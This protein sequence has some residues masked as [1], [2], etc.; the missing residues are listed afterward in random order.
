MLRFF[1]LATIL[2]Y[3]RHGLLL[4]AFYIKM[5]AVSQIKKRWW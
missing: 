2:Q 1:S 5:A 4:N 3:G